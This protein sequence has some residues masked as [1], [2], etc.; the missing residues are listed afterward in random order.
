MRNPARAV[1]RLPRL[2]GLGKQ[3]MDEF[4]TFAAKHDEVW[5]LAE[6]FA[7]PGYKGPSDNLVAAWER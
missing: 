5:V 1:A 2:R 6:R 4:D 7:T 3:L